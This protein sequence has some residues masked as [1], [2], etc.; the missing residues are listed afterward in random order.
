[1][2]TQLQQTAAPQQTRIVAASGRLRFGMELASY[3]LA[4]PAAARTVLAFRHYNAFR[5]GL[6]TPMLGASLLLYLASRQR[7]SKRTGP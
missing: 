3:A 4:V 2:P 7:P 1:M 5:F 6:S